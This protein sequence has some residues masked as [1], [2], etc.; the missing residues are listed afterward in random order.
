MNDGAVLIVEDEPMILLDLE[1]G[2][3]EAWFQF[4]GGRNAAQALAAF[5]PIQATSALP[6]AGHAGVEMRCIGTPIPHQNLPY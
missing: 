6:E 3:E 5:D 1:S 4:V 2:L